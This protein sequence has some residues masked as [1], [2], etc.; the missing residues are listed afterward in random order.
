MSELTDWAAEWIT[1][2]VAD[3]GAHG[4]GSRRTIA[5]SGETW[6]YLTD[7]AEIDRQLH[8]LQ[9]SNPRPPGRYA[10]T[11]E[12]ALHGGDSL[13][14]YAVQHREHAAPEQIRLALPFR[15]QLMG[16]TRPT[17]PIIDLTSGSAP[18]V[19]APTAAAAHGDESA[20]YWSEQYDRPHGVPWL[21]E[22]PQPTTAPAHPR[23]KQQIMRENT[24]AAAQPAPPSAPRPGNAPQVRSAAEALGSARRYLDAALMAGFGILCFVISGAR[25]TDKPAIVII[26]GIG[27]LLY[28]AY[29][30]L[31]R[32][33]Y[34]MPYLIYG[35]A[36]LGVAFFIFH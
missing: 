36:I 4:P 29:I 7:D 17:G 10:V 25:T 20:R 30:A 26:V 32:G 31:S 34:V 21:N 8:E 28:S 6:H 24:I 18:F 9:P 13:Q 15:R 5:L 1:K 19:P 12:R 3:G 22:P 33:G 11:Y 27:A 14:I 35:L 16:A 23:G 2:L